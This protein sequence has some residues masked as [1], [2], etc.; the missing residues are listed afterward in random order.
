MTKRSLP[1][2]VMPRFHHL[3]E[4]D[5]SDLKRAISK[6]GGVKF[7]ANKANLRSQ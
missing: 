6:F 5:R 3:D 4:D 2:N 7:I 1:S